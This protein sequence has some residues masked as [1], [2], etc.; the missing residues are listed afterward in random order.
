MTYYNF[1]VYKYSVLFLVVLPYIKYITVIQSR[2]FPL[3]SITC[4]SRFA[5]CARIRKKREN[6]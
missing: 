4:L 2:A 5:S 3:V 6:K 1:T